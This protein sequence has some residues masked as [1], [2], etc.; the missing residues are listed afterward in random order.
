MT[1]R[2]DLVILG[3]GTSGLSA[4][5]EASA[6]TSDV[7]L[8]DP[9]PLGT[10]CARVGCMPSKALIHVA[11]AFAE[12][13]FMAM[14][15][16]SGTDALQAQT[17]A[18]MEHVRTLRDRFAQGPT[19]H[20]ERLGK[21]YLRAH[22]HFTGPNR[23]SI[24]EDT[25]EAGAVIVATG[26]RPVVPPAWKAFGPERILTS[27]T[28]FDLPEIPQ[29]LAVVGLGAVG[30]ELSQALAQLG[31]DVHGYA[32]KPG[33]GGLTDPAVVDVAL[34]QLNRD[35]TLHLQGDVTVE[36]SASGS[37]KVG[38]AGQEHTVEAVLAAM[39]RQPNIE[40][41]NLEVLG[42]PSDDK[43]MP[44]IDPASLRAGDT[45]I[46]FAGDVS[47]IRPLQ[48]EAADEGRLAAHHALRPGSPCFSRRTPLSIVFTEPEIARV[49]LSY[50][51]LPESVVIGKAD[52]SSQSRAIMAGRAR[53]LIHV[54][55]DKQ[56]RLLGAEMA[57]PGAEH[58][59]HLL[60][61]AI[62]A[63]FS[64]LDALQMPFYH[65]VLEE[66][67]RSAL[68]DVRRQCPP[69]IRRPDLP[70]CGDSADPALG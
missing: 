14:A 46:F 61:W 64:V 57:V 6:L 65:P 24:G 59:A 19:K 8:V 33:V 18:V 30:A 16:I 17:R 49:G 52:F 7:L 67:L 47:G 68:Q 21:Q 43:G 1:R 25:I 23:L 50:R 4:F 53:G 28:V 13:E 22:A 40:N 29:T 42:L 48:H 20:T 60:G 10:T 32:R 26:T 51:G 35:V 69:R 11:R 56:G 36:E 38:Q 66:G 15:G 63:E 55:T 54:Y 62:Q 70:L 9:G 31:A 34:E 37:L 3:A 2:V 58:L 39:G 45:Q 44:E 5:K 27:D 41:L 12:R